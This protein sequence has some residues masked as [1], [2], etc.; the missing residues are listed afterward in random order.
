M[1]CRICH[2]NHSTGSFLVNDK[3][4]S[5][6]EKFEYFE[7]SD[8]GTLQIAEFPADMSVFYPDNYYSLKSELTFKD[9]F[10]QKI[11]DYIFYYQF[12]K[13]L[14]K[15]LS[16][17]MPNLSLEAFLKL[18]PKKSA[19]VLDVGCGEGKFLKS[20]YGLGFT[21]ITGID[22]FALKTVEKPFP[23]YKKTIAEIHDEFEV[24]TFNHVFEHVE[25]VHETLQKCHQILSD[26]GKII[27]RVPVKDS[28]A[29]ETYGEN[30]VQWDAPRHFQILTKKAFEILSKENGF[31]L[32]KYY[33]D[34]YKLQFTGSE[35]YKRGLTYQT[36]NSIF[37][38]E[39]IKNFNAKSQELNVQGTG[40]QV[41]VVLSK[42]NLK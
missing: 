33:N 37:T 35:K 18:K 29:Y 20:I 6:S 12:P 22:P 13:A 8:C 30:W 27:I 34:S 1:V 25:N 10:L 36:S 24:I 28:A 15:K 11:R 23:I 16:V 5:G 40:D 42:I 7:C 32:E 41:V 38:K 26:N 14:V 19:K 4:F 9:K 3:M 31:R 17:K 21:N 39:E 2:S